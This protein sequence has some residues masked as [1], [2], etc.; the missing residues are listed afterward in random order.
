VHHHPSAGST[1]KLFDSTVED[2]VENGLISD[3]ETLQNSISKI[4]L[5]EERAVC[6]KE[7]LPEVACSSS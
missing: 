5:L 6:C 7:Y 2:V 3:L 1:E 4:S